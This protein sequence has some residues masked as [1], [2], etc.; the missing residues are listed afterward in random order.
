ML[1]QYFKLFEMNKNL[2]SYEVWKKEGF[3]EGKKKNMFC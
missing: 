3:K 1:L 2:K